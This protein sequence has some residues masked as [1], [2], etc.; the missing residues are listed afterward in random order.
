MD[1]ARFIAVL[2]R[3]WAQRKRPVKTRE[4]PH[5]ALGRQGEK[6]AARFLR[7]QHGFK[8]LYRNFRSKYGGEVDLV[9]RDRAANALVF[10]EVKTRRSDAFGPPHAAI[11]PAKQARLLAGAQEWLRLL[12][13][14]EIV[15]RFDVVEVVIE[16]GP[17]ITLIRNAFSVPDAIYY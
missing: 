7:R 12:D 3:L 2:S 15:Y 9:C 14:P 17:R 4:A 6:L 11:T 8:I 5:L 10:V 13:R 1:P 16:D